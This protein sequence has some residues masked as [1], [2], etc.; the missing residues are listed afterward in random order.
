MTYRTRDGTVVWDTS[1]MNV[2]GRDTEQRQHPGRP[3]TEA[4]SPQ[5]NDGRRSGKSS[6]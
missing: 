4:P 6:E 2:S 5:R 1:D 3:S